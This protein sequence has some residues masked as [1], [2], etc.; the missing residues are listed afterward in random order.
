[1]VQVGVTLPLTRRLQHGGGSWLAWRRATFDDIDDKRPTAQLWKIPTLLLMR[2]I[3]L[4][5]VAE[6]LRTGFVR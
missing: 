6:V 1:M 4:R 2:G 5:W 3:R